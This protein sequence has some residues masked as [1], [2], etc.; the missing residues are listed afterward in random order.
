MLITESGNLCI[1]I[2]CIFHPTFSPFSLRN[3][4]IHNIINLKKDYPPMFLV[5]TFL[6]FTPV[7]CGVAIAQRGEHDM[8]CPVLLRWRKRRKD[9]QTAHPQRQQHHSSVNTYMCVY[10]TGTDSDRCTHPHT[11]THTQ[12]CMQ[13]R[14]SD[15]QTQI[16]L[17]F[18]CLFV[19]SVITV[20]KVSIHA[21][22][23]THFE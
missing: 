1:R 13:K 6:L 12:T 23:Y 20:N 11:Y 22:T 5:F 3:Y 19:S 9:T 18:V 15:I 17:L 16:A 4:N 10:A 7:K 2:K 8:I 21:Y 14:R